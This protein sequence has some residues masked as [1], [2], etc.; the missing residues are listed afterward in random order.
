MN[1]LGKGKELGITCALVPSDTEGVELGK[2]H[3][4]LGVPF[5][6]CPTRGHDVMV[7]IDAIIGGKEGSR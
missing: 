5:Y 7:P 6:N 3:D 1:Y 4:P 2:R